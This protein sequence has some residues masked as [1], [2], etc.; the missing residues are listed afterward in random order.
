[1]D[2]EALARVAAREGIKK[3]QGGQYDFRNVDPMDT[4][5]LP[6]LPVAK[7]EPANLKPKERG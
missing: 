1:M 5:F 4:S 6:P 7:L 3:L 2:K